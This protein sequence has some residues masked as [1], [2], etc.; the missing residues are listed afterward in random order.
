MAILNIIKLSQLEGAKRI[1]AEF[2]QPEYIVVEQKVQKCKYNKLKNLISILTDYHANGSYEILRNNVELLDKPDYALMLRTLNFVNDDF[3]Y[4]VK[5][6]SKHAYNFLK[7]TQLFGYEIVINKIGEPGEVYVVPP[8]P[9]KMSL[10]MNLFM[11]RAN[12]KI[13][14]KY[15]YIYLISSFGKKLLYRRVTGAVPLSIDKDSVRDI[16]VPILSKKLQVQID[17]LVEEHFR[18]R[19]KSH[20]LYSQAENLLLQELGLK[21][22][23]PQCNL[24]YTTTFSNVFNTHRIDAEYFQPIY[25]EVIKKLT[26]KAEVRPFK[27][28]IL[29]FQKGIEV[30]SDNYQEEGKPFIRVSNLSIHGLIERDQKYISE[31]LYD[32]LKEDYEPRLGD[33]LL[34]KDATPGIAYVVKEPVEGI[35]ASGIVRLIINEKKIDKEYLALCINSIIGRLQIERDGGG[36]VITHWKPSQ[37]KN[38]L[39]PLLP[40][41]IQ[42]KISSLVQQSYQA[43]QK[44]K[45]LLEEAK[46]KVEEEIEKLSFYQI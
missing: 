41:P 9:N 37:I 46:R 13:N 2:Y 3:K 22:F 15:L 39:I 30:G 25:E 33:F 5:Y 10:G 18:F 4:D 26:K 24:S 8:L 35:I 38:L 34:T 19:F 36:S 40:K 31:D 1:D 29:K 11:I 17:H 32:Q 7:K 21:D 20:T 27:N 45:Q 43:R 44:A 23:K 16:S 42:Q 12:Q 6:I 28:F 14:G